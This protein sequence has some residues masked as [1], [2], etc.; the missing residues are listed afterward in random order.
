MTSPSP[1][2]PTARADPSLASH[3][4]DNSYSNL[5]FGVHSPENH[6]S[7]APKK[8]RSLSPEPNQSASSSDP[9]SSPSLHKFT[10]AATVSA[11]A[12]LFKMKPSIEYNAPS[13]KR[14][15]P[16]RPALSAL[17]GPSNV[18]RQT[19]SAVSIP[20]GVGQDKGTLPAPLH[21]PRRAFSAMISSAE[22]MTEPSSDD[23]SDVQT[24]SPAAAYAKRHQ[25]RM[26]RRCDGSDDLRPLHGAG[27]LG[28]RDREIF[29]DR[30][31][32]KGCSPR[33]LA[34]FGVKEV[35]NKILPCH[36]VSEDGLVRITCSTVSNGFQL[37][38]NDAD[39]TF[40]LKALSMEPT[41]RRCLASLLLIVGLSMSTK[42]DTFLV[43][44]T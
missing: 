44:S 3:T 14:I 40:S 43:L 31:V 19:Q 34:G 5:F 32:A 23:Y 24:S 1:S 41:R 27:S 26:I 4:T 35:E 25:A 28:K 9:P 12:P 30:A 10:R 17:V 38:G 16:R 39:L 20:S 33:S 13:T 8:R 7:P 29:Q 11:G 42:V 36:R 15:P 6:P 21:P 22:L 2:A 37:R 18:S